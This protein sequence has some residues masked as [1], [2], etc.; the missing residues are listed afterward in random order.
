[1]LNI[2]FD[3]AQRHGRFTPLAASPVI[4]VAGQAVTYR[5]RGKLH[6]ATVLA[7]GIGA[8]DEPEYYLSTRVKVLRYAIVGV[9]EQRMVA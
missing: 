7:V 6:T 2:L 9:C 1:M 4:P 3:I 8:F 5:Q